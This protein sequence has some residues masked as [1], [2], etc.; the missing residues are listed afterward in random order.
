M[1]LT[2]KTD[3]YSMI[4]ALV[5][6]STGIELTKEKDYLIDYRLGPVADELGFL[7]LDTFFASLRMGISE[8]HRKKIMEALTTNE[9]SFFR[10]RYPFEVIQTQLLPD[11]LKKNMENLPLRIWSAVC[12]SG[13]EAYSLAF[14]LQELPSKL[15]Q[16]LQIYGSDI[17][18]KMI[19]KAKRGEYNH[20]EVTRGLNPSQ[21]EKYFDRTN[22]SFIV[23]ENYKK[24]IDFFEFN[25]LT[26]NYPIE[27]MDLI[28]LRNVLIYFRNSTREKII[29]EVARVLK[30]EG[31]LI[32]GATEY[33]KNYE[34][35]FTQEIVGKTTYYIRKKL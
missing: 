8:L 35:Y 18:T 29:Q 7:D 26:I 5:L 9:T 25:L 3:H 1:D 16:N 28:L 24:K 31:C 23:K 11:L 33:L 34:A 22:K 19:E 27:Q 12:S 4:R 14:I 10:D 17:S 2:L 30:P 15:Q 21:I 20:F 13:Q 6:D 32:L